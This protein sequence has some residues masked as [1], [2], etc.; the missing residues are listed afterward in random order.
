MAISALLRSKRVTS[1]RGKEKPLCK[2]DIV[3]QRNIRMSGMRG[4]R[5]HQI[6]GQVEWFAGTYV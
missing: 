3:Y 1:I 5:N 4:R 2:T 6:T